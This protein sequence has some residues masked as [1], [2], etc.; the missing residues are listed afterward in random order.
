MVAVGSR[1]GIPP[2]LVGKI[3]NGFGMERDMDEFP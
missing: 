2:W 1:D 3:E